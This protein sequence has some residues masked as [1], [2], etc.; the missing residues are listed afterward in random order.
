[1]EG[2]DRRTFLR[3][4]AG[5]AALSMLPL[6]A[7][8]T[9]TPLPQVAA[10]AGPAAVLVDGT[11]FEALPDRHAI[12][13][14]GAQGERRVSG[15]G[16]A[17]GKLNFPIG[18]TIA[19]GL[20]YVVECGNHRVQIFDQDLRSLGAL[21]EGELLYPGGIATM[22]DEILVADSRNARIVGFLANG[23]MTRSFGT[24]V[25]RAPR[26]LAPIDDTVIVADPGLRKVVELDGNGKVRRELG[27]DWVLP[28]DVATDGTHVFVADASTSQLAVLDRQG[29]RVDTIALDAAARAVSFGAD[30]MLYVS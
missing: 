20:V 25:L 7:C 3:L 30:G 29:R 5:S 23:D 9:T 26:G 6:G 11:R 4:S 22:A 24:E 1:M 10:A 13:A 8:T 19:G 16:S 28:W 27:G 15:V 14:T 17:H 12:V 18:V 21:G 2:M